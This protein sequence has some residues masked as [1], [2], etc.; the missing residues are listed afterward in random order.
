MLS[1]RSH[2]FGVW[3]RGLG[4]AALQ[5]LGSGCGV[6]QILEF[7]G[8]G[9]GRGIFEAFGVWGMMYFWVEGCGHE[10]AG[11]L[12]AA[13]HSGDS[14]PEG[15]AV[16]HPVRARRA[17]HHG[18]KKTQGSCSSTGMGPFQGNSMARNTFLLCSMSLCLPACLSVCLSV[19]LSVSESKE[20]KH[21]LAPQPNCMLY[22]SDPEGS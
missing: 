12:Q 19:Y 18:G 17:D 9:L 2:T 15:G 5:S 10:L 22:V 3:G 11:P 1:R 21:L 7:G 14:D 6:G 13:I 8:T 4:C 20:Q 16:C